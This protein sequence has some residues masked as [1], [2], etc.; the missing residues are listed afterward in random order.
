MFSIEPTHTCQFQRE[1]NKFNSISNSSQVSKQ[2][3]NINIQIQREK[4]VKKI[5]FK[6][7]CLNFLKIISSLCIFFYY[8]PHSE[9]QYF[10]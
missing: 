1:K 2:F 9:K 4:G 5:S 10:P 8:K 3:F 6:W 7:I